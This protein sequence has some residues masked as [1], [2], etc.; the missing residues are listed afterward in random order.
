MSN[1]PAQVYK[2][3]D[4]LVNGDVDNFEITIQNPNKKGE[5]FMGE[6]L[7]V[8]LKHKKSHKE[9]NV[10]VKQAFREKAIRDSIPIRDI[11]MNEIYFYSKIWARLD[12]FQQ[13]VPTKYHFQ[14]IPKCLASVSNENSEY[15]VMENLKL[16]HFQ[17][18][19][20]K[21]PLSKE[22]YQLIV[23]EYGKF[24]GISF[25]YKA[26]YP[27]EYAEMAK[28]LV[29]IY[30]DMS[31]REFFQNGIKYLYEIGIE[32]LQPG[33]DD[34]VIEKFRPYLENYLDV[35]VD[36]VKLKTK[37]T[38]ITHGDCWS[39]N[40]MFKYYDA[41]NVTDV[42]FFDFQLAREASPCCD[43]SYCIYSGAPKEVLQD[44]DRYLQIYH[45][46]LSTTLREFG[47]DPEEIY[48]LQAL[49]KDWKIFCKLGITMGLMIWKFKTTYDEELKDF[50]D[51]TS[52]EQEQI[53]LT[54]YDKDAFRK[55]ARDL[56]CHLYESDFL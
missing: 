23:R 49:K 14:K 4:Q 54:G 41:K 39:N 46:S 31:G 50:T 40:M 43:L 51:I 5:G 47:C 19:E 13:Q 32:S 25:A 3:L 10:I 16:Q 20:K 45:D 21:I 18:H 8:S 27:E 34:A 35:F 55:R 30:A 38:V 48:P 6:M 7:F 22:H 24:H 28:G 36:S 9:V 53:F 1:I 12:K 26:L 33:V 52:D 42:R 29:D 44:L 37:Y 17:T 11:F 15:L 2:T 56:L